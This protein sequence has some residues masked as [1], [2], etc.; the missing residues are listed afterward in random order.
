MHEGNHD[1][2][3]RA[4]FEKYCPA[5]DD[6][7]PFGLDTLLDFDGFGVRLLPDFYEF[8]RG[9]V[10]THGHLGFSLNRIVGVTAL[11]AAKRIGKNVICGH[12]HR[13]GIVSESTG[14]GGKLQ[15]VTGMEV[16]HLM[17][18]GKADYLRNGWANW[19]CTFAIVDISGRLVSPH[20]VP[21]A[22][23]GSFIADR[24]CRR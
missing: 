17:D 7:N 9:W 4:Y 13:A 18:I 5:L 8:A 3:P 6:Y 19:Q 2:R 10:S 22:P 20:V 12:T 11:N 21:V 23:D 15:T 14:Y 24:R 1:L 16:G